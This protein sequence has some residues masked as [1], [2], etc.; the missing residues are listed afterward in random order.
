MIYVLTKS[1][2]HRLQK[3]M[4]F[5]EKESKC[6]WGKD[7]KIWRDSE[8]KR[9]WKS[10]KYESKT[11]MSLDNNKNML[12]KKFPKTITTEIS[13][14]RLCLMSKVD[15]IFIKRSIN[16]I[17]QQEMPQRKILKKFTEF[18]IINLVTVPWIKRK[19]IVKHLK[20]DLITTLITKEPWP[21]QIN[22]VT[23]RKNLD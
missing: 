8:E 1:D 3:T 15:K 5:K 22:M 21:T 20:W 19:D 13:I 6:L 14:E 23:I 12:E 10:K 17:F 2:R 16:H 11:E 18:L 7:R 4:S 9:W